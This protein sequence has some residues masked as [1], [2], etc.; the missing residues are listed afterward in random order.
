MNARRALASLLLAA[1]VW[2]AAAQGALGD[3]V[4][5]RGDQGRDVGALQALLASSGYPVTT[6]GRYGRATVRAVRRFQRSAGMTVSGRAGRPTVQA[7][8]AVGGS[9]A[10]GAGQAAPAQSPPAPT[11]TKA[12]PPVP[13]VSPVPAPGTPATVGADGLAVAPTGAPPAVAAIIAAANRIARTPYRY[14]GGHGSFTDTAYDCSGSVSYAL[15]GAGLVTAPLDSTGLSRWAD[16]GAGTWVSVYA[17]PGHVYLVVAG[18]RFDTSGRTKAGTRWQAAPR[19]AR[20][21]VVRHPAGL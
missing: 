14:G 8:R 13:A 7:L 16:A 11:S 9:T 20:G 19:S 4:L 15:R 12:P 6:D 3:R 10:P 5:G 17:N 18:L 2:P 1:A 21:F